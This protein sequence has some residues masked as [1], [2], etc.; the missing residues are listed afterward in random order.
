MLV[1]YQDTRQNAEHAKH[2]L[3]G[4]VFK[5]RNIRIRFASHAAA[6]R[7]KNLSSCVSNEYLE[8]AF[9]VFGKVER[10]VVIVDEKGRATGE[11]I[12]EFERKPSAAQCIQKCTESCF[13]LTNYPKPVIV[14]PLEQKDDED[15][16]PEK[17]LTRNPQ[18]QQ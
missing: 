3:D 6:V 5:G 9:S 12:V 1:F 11:G 16:L 17:S 10:A 4:S 15:G 13:L 14:E 8:M 18:Y 7:V 2:D